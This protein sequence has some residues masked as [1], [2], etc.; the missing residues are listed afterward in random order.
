MHTFQIN[1]HINENGI[2]SIKLPKEWAEKDV[3]KEFIKVPDLLV[4]NRVNS[5]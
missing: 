3:N 5:I 4:E 2:L 1:S